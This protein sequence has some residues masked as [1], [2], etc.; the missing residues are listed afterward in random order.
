MWKFSRHMELEIF[1]A[2]I[3]RPTPTFARKMAAY[4]ERIIA[5]KDWKQ[6]WP[7]LRFVGE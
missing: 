6:R 7:N 2:L 3:V 1:V 4:Q 5:K